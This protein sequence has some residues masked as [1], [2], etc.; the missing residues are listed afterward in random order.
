VQERGRL[1][2]RCS[3]RSASPGLSLERLAALASFPLCWSSPKAFYI[4][5]I[6]GDTYLDGPAKQGYF[7]PRLPRAINDQDGP[8]RQGHLGPTLLRSV[9][10]A[11]C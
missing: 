8:A 6:A 4:E 5:V 2:R 3:I 7:G 11:R 10:T 1:P 9:H